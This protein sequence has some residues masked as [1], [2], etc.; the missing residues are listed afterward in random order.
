MDI[1]QNRS[2]MYNRLMPGRKGYTDAFLNGVTEFVSF[3]CQQA[4][5]SNGNIRCPCSKCKNLKYLDPEEVKVHLYKKG[6]IPD[7]WYW[8]CHGESDPNLSGVFTTHPRTATLA[9]EGHTEHLSRFHSMVYDAVGPEFQMHNDQQID[10]SPNVDAQKFYDLLNIAQKPLWPG[11][12]DHTEL[13][14][15][16]RLLTIKS[17][18]NISQR[19][20]NQTVALMKET[21]PQDNLVPE[22]YYRTKKIVSK[23]GLTA[24]KIDCCVNGCMLFY[25]NEYTQLKECKFC[26]A[27]RYNKKKVGKD[28]YKEV[29]LKRM[30]YLPLIPRLKRLYAS[31]SS[32]S[33]MRW[34][35]ENRRESG[36]LCHPSDGEA[37]KHFDETYP[38][39]AAEPRNVRLGLCADGFTPFS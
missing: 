36:V 22:D 28:K 10:E 19:S 27:P 9:Q 38:D 1:R 5:L 17:E 33:N 35:Y 8:T 7:Y 12:N 18:G 23:L 21:H 34:H 32:V 39:F 26:G 6:F 14:V 13:S 11:C 29:P 37:W 2:W 4:Y 16:V 30:H 3:A 24:K 31:M 20:F 15:A 25:T